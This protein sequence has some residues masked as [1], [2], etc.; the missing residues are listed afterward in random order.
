MSAVWRMYG[1]QDYPASEPAVCAFKVQTGSQLRDFIQIKEVIDLQIYYNRPNELESLLYTEFFQ[2][3]N[4]SSK[5][6]KYY[7]DNPDT[8]DNITNEQHYS[9][10]YM[11]PDQDICYVYR[12][13]RQVNRCVCI[14]MLHVTSGDIFYLCLILLKGK[15]R[16]D[17]D[18]LTFNP[19]CGGGKPIL[20]RSYQ[21]STIAHGYVESVDDVR[22]TYKDM[23]LNGTGSQCRSYF[24]V[25]MLHGYA[26]H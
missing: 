21:Q 19:V 11:E 15:A 24:V 14:E 8:L 16:S 6:P 18:V 3:Y 23:C 2:Q 1:Y 7:A 26:M 22:M 20:C 25:L 10:V 12:P 9:K 17:K 5:L 13:V 4:A